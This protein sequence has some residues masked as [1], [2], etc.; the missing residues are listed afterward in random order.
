MKLIP[1][2]ACAALAA[3]LFPACST[4]SKQDGPAKASCCS[5]SGKCDTAHKKHQ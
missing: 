3:F 2:L 1:I 4:M 5:K